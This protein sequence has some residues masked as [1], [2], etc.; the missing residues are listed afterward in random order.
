MP[1]VPSPGR[2]GTLLG[3]NE[4][5]L[6]ELVSFLW[7]GELVS[8]AGCC[9]VA[10]RI[11]RTSWRKL[12]HQRGFA[13]YAV[14]RL[15]FKEVQVLELR[16]GQGWDAWQRK[17]H[18]GEHMLMLRHWHYGTTVLLTGGSNGWFDF[19]TFS[20]GCRNVFYSSGISED[21]DMA[22]GI[23][24]EFDP[25]GVLSV[26]QPGSCPV[27]RLPADPL[28]CWRWHA[29]IEMH[30]KEPP[31]LA[32]YYAPPGVQRSQRRLVLCASGLRAFGDAWRVGDGPDLVIHKG[33]QILPKI[34]WLAK[35][36][37]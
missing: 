26:A 24:R 22:D 16:G 11:S 17:S 31:G 10:R 20:G 19:Q 23:M 14:A 4:W 32:I 7:T 21:S 5:F 28:S 13:P 6:A 9:A 35:T 2:N 30:T 12:L 18:F 34:T 37:Q 1:P 27:F 25:R 15:S 3:A 29:E 36:A 8:F 33:C